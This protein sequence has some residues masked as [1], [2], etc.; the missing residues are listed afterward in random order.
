MDIPRRKLESVSD[1]I[2]PASN[3]FPSRGGFFRSHSLHDHQEHFLSK[4]SSFKKH[5][6]R[7]PLLHDPSCQKLGDAVSPLIDE[8]AWRGAADEA[9]LS[10][11]KFSLSQ[12]VLRQCAI[13]GPMVCVNLLQYSITVMSIMFV[14]HLGEL[15]LASASIAN[16]LAGVLGYYVLVILASLAFKRPLL[17]PSLPFH[18]ISSCKSRSRGERPGMCMQPARSH[19]PNNNNFSTHN[20]W[21]IFIRLM[22]LSLP[23]H[24]LIAI[25]AQSWTTWNVSCSQPD[26]ILW[27]VAPSQHVIC[28]GELVFLFSWWCFPF[29]QSWT[30]WNVE[31]S[32]P[33]HILRIITTSQHII[34]DEELVCFG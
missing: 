26:H 22:M 2:S 1:I 18:S 30:T 10:A 31:C 9:G 28:G 11:A 20:L 7:E 33:D 27:I 19:P 3:S 13:A 8:G 6:E 5:P 12:E 25:L 14:G 23:F 24:S 16:S 17:F 32:Q 4:S 34:C 21:C 29:P 15:E